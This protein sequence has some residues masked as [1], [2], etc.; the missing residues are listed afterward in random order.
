MGGPHNNKICK[1]VFLWCVCDKIFAESCHMKLSKFSNPELPK[2]P[3]C[4]CLSVPLSFVFSH[5]DRSWFIRKNTDGY[6]NSFSWFFMI[7]HHDNSW[8]GL[9]GTKWVNFVLAWLLQIQILGA[10]HI[11][12][13]R[14]VPFPPKHR[15]ISSSFT[16][17]NTHQITCFWCGLE[18][19]IH[20]IHVFWSHWYL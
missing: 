8:C 12:A 2:E 5:S 9:P 16:S 17:C 3:M 20:C 10:L 19:A 7:W 4:L 1:P 13:H 11:L 6:W 18:T 14:L 15:H